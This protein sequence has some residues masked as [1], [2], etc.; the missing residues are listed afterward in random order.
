M[1]ESYMRR[2]SNPPWPRVMRRYPVRVRRS[3]DRGCSGQVFSSEITRPGSRPCDLRGK[4]TRCIAS[5]QAKHRTR[6]VI[7]PVHEYTLLTRKSGD[8]VNDLWKSATG[9]TGEDTSSI[10]RHARLREGGWR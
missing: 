10:T 8:P 7:D 3:V 1:K 2:T 6:G 9:T 4:A 5:E